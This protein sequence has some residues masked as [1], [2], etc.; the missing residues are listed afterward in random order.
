[1]TCIF[2]LIV[3]LGILLPQPVTECPTN[4]PPSAASHTMTSSAWL[5]SY[6]HKS[7][8]TVRWNSHFSA[9]LHTGLSHAPVA[10]WANK[11]LPVAALALLSG[12]PDSVLVDDHRYVTLSACAAG[13][14]TMKGLL[15]VD[16]ATQHNGLI[17]AFL[18]QD[19]V[20]HNRATLH[21]YTENQSFSAHLPPLFLRRLS[22]WEG[23]L[24]ITA[25]A[26]STITN[27]DGN[28][29]AIVLPSADLD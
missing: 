5:L 20:V 10:W 29:H 24:G 22:D 15:W 8:N 23:H 26:S 12:P 9:L 3:T 25:I 6:D 13:V 27:Q 28:E 21:I 11:P 17:F 4:T 18:D 2:D 1:M 14:C 7:T 16:T 19:V